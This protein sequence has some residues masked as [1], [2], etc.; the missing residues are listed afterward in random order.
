MG[1]LALDPSCDLASVSNPPP[2]DYF[3]IAPQDQAARGTGAHE[4]VEGLA[5]G[6]MR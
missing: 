1:L 4:V 3:S 5:T 2:W 6:R